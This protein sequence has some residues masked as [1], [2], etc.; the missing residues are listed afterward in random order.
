MRGYVLVFQWKTF[1][2]AL[3]SRMPI[4]K[5]MLCRYDKFSELTETQNLK[6]QVYLWSCHNI[7]KQ[8]V[9]VQTQFNTLK[10]FEICDSF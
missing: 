4:Y 5:I 9:I 6:K 1:V 3:L 7:Y 10:A 2:P 8:P